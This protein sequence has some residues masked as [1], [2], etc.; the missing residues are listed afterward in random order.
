MVNL[1]DLHPEVHS[2]YVAPSAT[3]VGDVLIGDNVGVWNNVVIRGDLYD[4]RIGSNTSIGDNST[5]HTA[6]SLPTGMPATVE[7][8]ESTVIMN[9]C[10][11]YS[12][13]IGNNVYIGHN[14]VVL[15][16]AKIE[17]GAM[18]APNSVIPPGRYVPA[19]QYWAGNP[20]EY[21]RDLE[22]SEVYSIEQLSYAQRDLIT[23]YS[24]EFFEHSPAYL[25]KESTE[26]DLEPSSKTIYHLNE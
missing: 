13:T 9:D 8:G 25:K 3:I 19:K 1:Y 16:G 2:A 14:T 4:V 26:E 22:A 15:E 6:A 5:I 12:C 7:I 18:I 10:T 17:S 24:S 23:E 20:I 11:L 21:V